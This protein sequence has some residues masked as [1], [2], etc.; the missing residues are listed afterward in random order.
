[1]PSASP[2]GPDLFAPIQETRARMWIIAPA[3]NK[4]LVVHK[5]VLPSAIVYKITVLLHLF[6]VRPLEGWENKVCLLP[7]SI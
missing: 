5:Q 3:H 1:M 7:V 2:D 6:S 4:V